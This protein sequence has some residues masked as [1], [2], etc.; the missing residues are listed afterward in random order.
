VISI[1]CKKGPFAPRAT[2][3]PTGR[4]LS[5]AFLQLPQLEKE[6]ALVTSLFSPDLNTLDA[7]SAVPGTAHILRTH[8]RQGELQLAGRL[9]DRSDNRLG[10][11]LAL[12][13][14]SEINRKGRPGENAS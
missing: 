8:D 12:Q 6:K 7:T 2:G 10:N 11:I 3:E 9:S 14:V 5:C 1:G 4:S 13:S